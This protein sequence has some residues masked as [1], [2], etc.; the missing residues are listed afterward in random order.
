MFIKTKVSW[1]D[2]GSTRKSVTCW[3]LPLFAYYNSIEEVEN[4]IDRF[5]EDYS[6]PKYHVLCLNKIKGK[7]G[8][9]HEIRLSDSTP[10]YLLIT[11]SD[12]FIDFINSNLHSMDND[13]IVCSKTGVYVDFNNEH[14]HSVEKI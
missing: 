9:K 13:S 11:K 6:D 1:K 5:N 4:K 12:E 8:K 2:N 10:D 14:M 3:L 7:K